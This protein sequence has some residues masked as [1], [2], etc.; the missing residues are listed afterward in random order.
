MC[1]MTW[2]N[3]NAKQTVDHVMYTFSLDIFLYN[4]L[5]TDIG[6]LYLFYV[7]EINNIQ[8]TDVRSTTDVRPNIHFV[9]HTFT[10]ITNDCEA[11]EQTQNCENLQKCPDL[12]IIN[13]NKQSL[14]IVL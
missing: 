8:L 5:W 14:E 1:T 9:F 4:L 13:S 12:I 11:R 2:C 3:Y 6:E 10:C 7:S